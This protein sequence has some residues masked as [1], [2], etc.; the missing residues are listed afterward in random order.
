VSARAGI[1]HRYL[2]YLERYPAHPG[3]AVLRQIAAA[4]QTTPAALLG[5]GAD[6]PDGHAVAA[7]RPVT[8]KLLPVQ[9]RQLIAPGGVGR[10]AFSTAAGPVVLPVNFAVVDDA[11]VV[12][13]GGGTVIGAHACGQVA[14]EVDHIDEALRQGWS[15]LVR[16]EAH[17]VSQPDELRHVRGGGTGRPWVGGD[18]EAYVRI[19][20]SR[21]TGRRISVV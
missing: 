11:I 1:S 8:E 19:V 5:G 14:F 7:G 16:G 12:R 4:L 15:V 9:C 17:L 6:A 2:E 21:I 10:I 13:T 18:R 20:P 3:A